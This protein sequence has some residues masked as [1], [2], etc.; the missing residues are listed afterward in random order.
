MAAASLAFQTASAPFC[1][2][3]ERWYA[4]I[5]E[6]AVGP[7]KSWRAVVDAL[8]NGELQKLSEH[9]RACDWEQRNIL[10]LETWACSLCAAPAYLRLRVRNRRYN[11]RLLSWCRVMPREK[12]PQ[13][14]AA[15]CGAGT[16]TR[17]M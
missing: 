7:A 10:G 6:Y 17:T 3:C 8:E 5:N 9:A 13:L 1:E 2:A 14:G 12:L 15:I 11:L 4:R 16:E